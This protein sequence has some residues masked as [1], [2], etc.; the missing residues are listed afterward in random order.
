MRRASKW[1]AWLGCL[2]AIGCVAVSGRCLGAEEATDEEFTI[3][4]E[5]EMPSGFPAPT[6]VGRIEVKQ[7]PAYRRATATGMGQFWTLFRHIKQTD[8]AMTAPVEMDYGPAGAGGGGSASMSFLYER[9]NQGA[10]GKQGGVEV[11]DVEAATVVSIGC[12][13]RQTAAA[14][15]EAQDRLLLWLDENGGYAPSG[16]LRVMGYNSP[17]VPREKNFFEVQIPVEISTD[18]KPIRTDERITTQ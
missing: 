10:A 9:P 3:I 13:G 4:K 15:S 2:G 18:V 8:V 12:R 1:M 7:Y 6:P 5:A 17:F 11:M 16:S 14:V